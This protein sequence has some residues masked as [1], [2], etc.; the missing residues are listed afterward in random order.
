MINARYVKGKGFEI[1]RYIPTKNKQEDS[2]SKE[3][4]KSEEVI[5]KCQV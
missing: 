1:T 4:I 3:I 2:N 5:K